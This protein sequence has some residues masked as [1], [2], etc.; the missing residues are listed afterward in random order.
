[1]S[2]ETK[3]LVVGDGGVSAPAV[4]QAAEILASGGLVAFPTETV[5]GIGANADS[6]DALGRLHAL[7]ERPPD[8]PFSVHIG[9]RAALRHHVDDVPV[10]GRKLMDRFWPG[11]LTIVFGD[12]EDSV[13]VRLP[14]HEVGAA[15]LRAAGVPIVAPSANRAGGTPANTADEVL[16]AFDGKIDAVLDDGSAPLMQS[17]TVVRV[18]RSGWEMLR[19]GIISR[20]MIARALKMNVLFLCTGNSCRSPIAEFLCRR[21]LA[22]RLRLSEPELLA[23]GYKIESAGTATAG[24]GGPSQGALAAAAQTGLDISDHRA[25]A[26]TPELLRDSDRVYAMTRGHLLA[27]KSMCPDAADR[28]ELMDP[29]GGDVEDPI[30]Y[31]PKRF[32]RIVRQIEACLERRA[33]DL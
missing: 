26:M 17:S 8:K 14:A 30:G 1:M 11:P 2:T 23:V 7:K 25:Q 19:E 22:G 5:Y 9:D 15:F 32:G 20:S 13:G 28:V 6:P 27:A 12:G 24:G 10:T 18:W 21:L 3:R 29:D 31:P 16:A 33:K 4:K